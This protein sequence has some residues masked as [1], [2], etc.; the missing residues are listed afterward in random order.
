MEKKTALQE[1]IALIR[2]DIER[3]FS[4]ELK[5]LESAFEIHKTYLVGRKMAPGDFIENVKKELEAFA[6]KLEEDNLE[7]KEIMTLIQTLEERCTKMGVGL[8]PV[9]DRPAEPRII[10]TDVL[11]GGA[12]RNGAAATFKRE[13][14]SDL[15]P[16]E[17]FSRNDL[18]FL[19]RALKSLGFEVIGAHELLGDPKVGPQE[20]PKQGPSE[21]I[22][23]GATF[24]EWIVV[25]GGVMKGKREGPDLKAY[26]KLAENDIFYGKHRYQRHTIV[27]K[28]P[29]AAELE[30]AAVKFCAE[31]RKMLEGVSGAK[32][33]AKKSCG[34]TDG[35]T[36]VFTTAGRVEDVPRKH[37]VHILDT[38]RDDEW[39]VTKG[40]YI[41]S[42]KQRRP[43]RACL[44]TQ[45]SDLARDNCYDATEVTFK[46]PREAALT[47]AASDY[48]ESASSWPLPNKTG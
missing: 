26:L 16:V 8:D 17:V 40:A 33:P 43:L 15:Q 29:R 35:E 22:L 48:I 39:I 10:Y 45:R 44:D 11:D 31:Y 7:A 42:G 24:E 37:Y 5:E 6:I 2:K 13:G 38:V 41:V 32:K 20:D 28:G 12:V 1:L 30:V 47:H 21:D 19:V 4:V 23:D 27:F 18:G 25:V 46:G 9:P 34:D 14:R 36:Y 3:L